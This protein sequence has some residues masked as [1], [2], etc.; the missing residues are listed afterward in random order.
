MADGSRCL[1]RFLDALPVRRHGY[2][3]WACFWLIAPTIDTTYQLLLHPIVPRCSVGVGGWDVP[4]SSSLSLVPIPR[5]SSCDSVRSPHPL[6]QSAHLWE[7]AIKPARAPLRTT[8]SYHAAVCA[9]SSDI[10]ARPAITWYCDY[11]RT[12]RRLQFRVLVP[13]NDCYFGIL[14]KPYLSHIIHLLMNAFAAVHD[15]TITAAKKLIPMTLLYPSGCCPSVPKYDAA[16][17]TVQR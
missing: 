16:I 8:N 1:Y 5:T 15:G 9:C 4:T 7:S 17:R 2:R 12:A 13:C 10:I 3:R 14:T 11:T 6:I